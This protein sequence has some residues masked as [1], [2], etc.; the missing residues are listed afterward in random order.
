MKS[1]C[2][3]KTVRPFY[4]GLVCLAVASLCTFVAFVIVYRYV[5]FVRPVEHFA[6]VIDAGSTKTRSNLYHIRIRLEAL[7]GDDEP[8]SGANFTRLPLNELVK[9]EQLSSCVNG[10]AVAKLASEAEANKVMSQCVGKFSRQIKRLRFV[11]PDGDSPDQ[12][13][14]CASLIDLRE[15]DAIRDH[16]INSVTRLYLGATAGLRTLELIKPIEA[17][18]KLRWLEAALNTSNREALGLPTINRGFMDILSGFQEAAFS[19]LS[20]NFLCGQ[21]SFGDNPLKSAQIHRSPNS[22][23]N[24]DTQSKLAN[25]NNNNNMI[26]TVE[27]GGN[28]AQIAF[29]QIDGRQTDDGFE[30]RNL[31][32]FDANYALEAKSD[33]CIGLSQ[34]ELRV[35]LISVRRALADRLAKW[36]NES[37]GTLDIESPCLALGARVAY[38]P[39]E[40]LELARLP[41]MLVG[42]NRKDPIE[43]SLD[44]TK[45]TQIRLLGLG[46]QSQCDSMLGQLIEPAECSKLFALCSGPKLKSGP[47]KQ[48]P[49]VT[50]SAFNNLVGVLDLNKSAITA[51][52]GQAKTEANQLDAAIEQ[53]LGGH[54][55]DYSLF[56]DS[57]A[58]FCSTRLELF[59]TRYPKLRPEYRNITCFSLHYMDRLLVEFYGFS[60]ASKSWNQLRF[61]ILEPSATRS[62]SLCPSPPEVGWSMGLLLNATSDE[63]ARRLAAEQPDADADT[64]SNGVYYHHSS[65]WRFVLRTLLLLMFACLLLAVGLALTGFVVVSRWRRQDYADFTASAGCCPSADADAA[66][67]QLHY[68]NQLRYT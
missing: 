20:V 2:E 34:A 1:N 44:P 53:T 27:L 6:I 18:R 10:K 39:S 30:R 25:A 12:L 40:L 31:S 68:R 51:N 56:K 33:P 41:C 28:S 4:F 13:D 24:S 65:S 32:I 37:S 46:F 43:W 15:L 17:R 3:I 57:V 62:D 52:E 26:G 11:D 5:S 7:E 55:L 29:N 60:P 19:W 59:A 21:L 23:S 14:G 45:V 22:N 49:F 67:R 47:P 64:I 42:G 48:V 50:V 36:S 61:L 9:I 38:T 54:S 58:R 63:L 8:K 35:N 16:R 66:T